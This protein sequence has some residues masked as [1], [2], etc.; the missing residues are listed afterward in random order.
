MGD[1]DRSHRW[2]RGLCF[3]ITE[4]LRKI[5]GPSSKVGGER[6]NKGFRDAIS[7][8]SA[9]LILDEFLHGDYGIINQHASALDLA[10][11]SRND[12]S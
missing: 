3:N 1:V 12:C 10:S 7:T 4:A 2:H 11:F 9:N 5:R 8:P 6:S